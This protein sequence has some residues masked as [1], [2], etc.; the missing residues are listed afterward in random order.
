MD[1]DFSKG[2]WWRKLRGGYWVYWHNIGW[3]KVSKKVFDR[4][5]KERLNMPVNSYEEWD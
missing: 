1:I 4:V 3:E 5:K 2:R